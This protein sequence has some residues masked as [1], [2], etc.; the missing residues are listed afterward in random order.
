[1][2]SRPSDSAD[3]QAGGR[4]GPL[5]V[6][7][8]QR[9]HAHHHQVGAMDA[10]VALGDH[11]PDAQQPRTPGRPVA[12]RARASGSLGT[13]HFA[14]D[15]PQADQYGRSRQIQKRKVDAD[16]VVGLTATVGAWYR[17]GG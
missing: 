6:G 9:Q 2:P 4:G 15:D 5:A 3:R 14:G 10:L 17:K 11:E 1:M 16:T 7:E 13:G 8:L 12:R